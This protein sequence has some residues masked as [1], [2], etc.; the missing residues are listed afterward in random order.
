MTK[1][2]LTDFEFLSSLQEE[3]DREMQQIREDRIRVN[4]RIFKAVESVRGRRFLNS[5]K[6]CLDSV[7][8]DGFLDLVKTP[9]GQYQQEKTD[10]ISGYW[11][12]QW[13]S[14]MEADDFAGNV[15][16]KLKDKLYIRAP[17]SS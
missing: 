4:N 15:Y 7:E 13:R 2:E 5:L 3:F 9:K 6:R 1:E 8:Y 10:R 16:I 17:Y 11:V 12:E 14:G